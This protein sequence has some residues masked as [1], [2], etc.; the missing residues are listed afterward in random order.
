MIA[1]SARQVVI[2]NDVKSDYIEQAIFILRDGD[3]A[4]LP[5]KPEKDMV[6]EAER[7]IRSYM[8]TIRSYKLRGKWR[9]FKNVVLSKKCVFAALTIAAAAAALF[10]SLIHI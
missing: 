6:V 10:L 2:I 3:N 7:I 9:Y 1:K 8:S 5:R 4:K